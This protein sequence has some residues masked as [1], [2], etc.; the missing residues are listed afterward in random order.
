MHWD[1]VLVAAIPEVQVTRILDER[2]PSCVF[3][4]VVTDDTAFLVVG[5]RAAERSHYYFALV[6]REEASDPLSE[7]NPTPWVMGEVV[8]HPD[9]VRVDDAGDHSLCA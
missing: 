3:I 1:S 2:L 6:P 9:R 5:V 7:R 8:I 4:E